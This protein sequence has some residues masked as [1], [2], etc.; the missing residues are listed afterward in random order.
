VQYPEDTGFKK[1]GPVPNTR[2]GKNALGFV[3][4]N[5]GAIDKTLLFD[6]ELLGIGDNAKAIRAQGTWVAGPLAED[7]AA[8]APTST[9]APA[10]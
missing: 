9:R 10:E 5:N 6:V 3:V 4:V 2:S 7:P 8:R 1:I